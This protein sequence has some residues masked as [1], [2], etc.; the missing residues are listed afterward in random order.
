MGTSYNTASLSSA[1][2]S[3]SCGCGVSGSQKKNT[4]SMRVATR[5]GFA[6]FGETVYY[7]RDPEAA[8]AAQQ[9]QT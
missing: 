3:T 8:P 1:F 9:R 5:A 4:A 2:T 7:S 6:P